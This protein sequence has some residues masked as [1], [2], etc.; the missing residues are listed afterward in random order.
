VQTFTLNPTVS[1]RPAFN[2][3]L[4][5]HLSVGAGFD[6]VRGTV[7]LNRQLDFVDSEGTLRLGAGTW[8]YSG[9]FGV[10]THW[11]SDKLVVGLAYRAAVALRFNGS[12]DFTVPPEF[13]AQLQDQ[14]VST[15]LL[16]PHTVSLGI[17]AQVSRLRLALD[18]TYT[19][20]SK[21]QLLTLRFADAGLQTTLRFNWSDTVTVRAGAE[22]SLF[23]RGAGRGLLLRLGF[24]FDPSPAPSTT[25][26]P[27][28][29]DA[30]RLLFSAGAGYRFGN[31]SIDAGYLF[32]F[33]LPRASEPDAFPARYSGI[34]HVLG[35][36][37]GFKQ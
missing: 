29:P 24:G 37:L 19:T 14:D 35:V 34:A 2:E 9:N 25:L 12:A 20:W 6:L 3:W 11:L 10:S 33:L 27:S 16:L 23:G 31:F 36:S 28:L 7:E 30:S 1:W 8:G 5:E 13:Q 32:V 22:L 4:H 26:S 18:A 17:A 15:R 21:F